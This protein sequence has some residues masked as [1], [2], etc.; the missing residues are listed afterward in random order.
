MFQD[1]TFGGIGWHLQFTYEQNYTEKHFTH[2]IGVICSL[3]THLYST[4]EF[5]SFQQSCELLFHWKQNKL[6]F[7]PHW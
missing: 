6:F 2:S 7:F 1:L 4:S 3:Q 5:R